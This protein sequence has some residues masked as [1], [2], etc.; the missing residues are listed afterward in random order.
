MLD[1]ELNMRFGL[2]GFVWV[3][4]K[5]FGSLKRHLGPSSKLKKIFL[6]ILKIQEYKTSTRKNCIKLNR[7]LGQVE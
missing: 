6:E 1:L 5:A 4:N 2:I 3:S 7:I